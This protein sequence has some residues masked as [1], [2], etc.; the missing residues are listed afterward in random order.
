[1]RVI[2]ILI[3]T[4]IIFYDLIYIYKCLL[5]MKLYKK[6]FRILKNKRSL[7]SFLTIWQYFLLH[8][9]WFLA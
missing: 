6:F 8:N 9:V 1:M 7:E 5:I 4:I 2:N 3:F